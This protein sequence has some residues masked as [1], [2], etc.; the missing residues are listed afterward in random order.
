MNK[1]LENVAEYIVENKRRKNPL[2]LSY[3]F[4]LEGK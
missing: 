1:I 3:S 2:A 4:P